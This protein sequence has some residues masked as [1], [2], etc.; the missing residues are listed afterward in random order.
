[1]IADPFLFLINPKYVPYYKL[2]SAT[3]SLF[4]LKMLYGPERLEN[5]ITRKA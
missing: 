4:R 3:F 5:N 2:N 1:M